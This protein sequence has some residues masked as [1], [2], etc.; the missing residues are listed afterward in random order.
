MLGPLTGLKKTVEAQAMVHADEQG[1]LNDERLKTEGDVYFGKPQEYANHRCS[2][3]EC[4]GCKKPYFGGLIDCEQEMQQNDDEEAKT[5]PEDL[6]CQDCVLKEIGA[7]KDICETH[8]KAQIDWKCMYC[9][10]VAVFF[11][12]GTHYM[13][14]RCHTGWHGN[15]PEP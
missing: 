12:F 11:C 5:K 7:G 3:Y 6:L 2:F 9:C 4:H 15:G 14:N 8:G 13:C 10:S 1:I